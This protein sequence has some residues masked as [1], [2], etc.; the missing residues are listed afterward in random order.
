MTGS[1]A[2]DVV[3]GLVFVYLLY[4]LLA[5]LVQEISVSYL[6]LSL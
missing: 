2:I 1:V 6:T 5:S 3:L 4:S